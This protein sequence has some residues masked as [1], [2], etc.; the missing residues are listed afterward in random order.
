M[1]EEMCG[2]HGVEILRRSLRY[3]LDREVEGSQR[4]RKPGKGEKDASGTRSFRN[5]TK[6]G[7]VGNF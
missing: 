7:G 4:K 1:K 6:V 2:D 3:G 5:T